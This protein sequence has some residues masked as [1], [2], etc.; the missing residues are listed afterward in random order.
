MIFAFISG[1]KVFFDC[2]P[3]FVCQITFVICC[4][5]FFFHI[6][7]YTTFL[8][9][10]QALNPLPRKEG[11]SAGV[12]VIN[13]TCDFN[14][15]PRKEGD[16]WHIY[17]QSPSFNFNP[18]PRKEGDQPHRAA[19]WRA[20]YFNPLPRKEGDRRWKKKRTKGII[21]IHSLV[22]RETSPSSPCVHSAH[23]SIHSL[24]KRETLPW[25][26]PPPDW[27]FQSTPS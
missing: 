4:L 19:F 8:L 25:F 3:L 17:K 11:D 23:I 20:R 2:F 13:R 10:T 14:P 26:T 9:W 24:V 5:I 15:L 12:L 6:S 16:S 18:L 7:Y 21:S 27:Q 1:W 22:K